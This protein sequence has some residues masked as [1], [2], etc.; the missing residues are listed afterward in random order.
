MGYAFTALLV[1][2]GKL[3]PVTFG[4]SNYEEAE[5]I[6]PAIAASLAARLQSF[7]MNDPVPVWR[8]RDARQSA[9]GRNEELLPQ[10]P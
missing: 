8:S 10:P 4:A 1:R 2:R 7:R 5:I 6:A 3:L 9:T